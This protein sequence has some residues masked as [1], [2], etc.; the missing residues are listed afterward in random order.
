MRSEGRR[1]VEIK[2]KRQ[3]RGVLN[4]S[5]AGA[6]VRGDRE[7]KQGNTHCH[8]AAR[9]ICAC[10][11]SQGECRF[12]KLMFESFLLQQSSSQSVSAVQCRG[13]ITQQFYHERKQ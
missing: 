5:P 13:F 2:T 7:E 12:H 1:G 4:H 11:G 6:A 9:A 3:Q 10:K 8:S